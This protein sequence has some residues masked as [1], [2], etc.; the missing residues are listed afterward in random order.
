VEPELAMW[1][2]YTLE[3]KVTPI[4]E[5]RIK[6]CLNEVL[7]DNKLVFFSLNS[8]DKD[9]YDSDPLNDEQEDIERTH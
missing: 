1:L 7:K 9:D 4:I 3:Y 8:E 2:N 6:N 5:E